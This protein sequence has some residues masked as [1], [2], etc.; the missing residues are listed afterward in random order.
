MMKI[1]DSVVYVVVLES[2]NVVVFAS[3]KGGDDISAIF[4]ACQLS[5]GKADNTGWVRSA[6]MECI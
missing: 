6:V 1:E 2:E 4:W 3:E 5:V